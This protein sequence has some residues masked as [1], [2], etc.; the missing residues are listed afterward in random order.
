MSIFTRREHEVCNKSQS[1]RTKTT[2]RISTTR[3]CWAKT[4]GF[5]SVC[6]RSNPLKE[7]EPEL[8]RSQVNLRA[9]CTQL[10]LI[11]SNQ[12][13]CRPDQRAQTEGSIHD[14]DRHVQT[15]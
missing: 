5:G 4:S 2:E 1:Q 6:C 15:S 9:W 7:E 8:L 14:I 3:R 11:T 10:R 13:N 12:P